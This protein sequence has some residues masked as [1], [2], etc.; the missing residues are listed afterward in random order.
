VYAVYKKKM[1]QLLKNYRWGEIVITPALMMGIDD[2]IL[3][4]IVFGGVKEFE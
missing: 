1:A 4:Q 2:I 3:D